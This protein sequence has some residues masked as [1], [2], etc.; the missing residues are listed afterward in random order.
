MQV[1]KRL[2]RLWLPSLLLALTIPACSEPV[3]EG[4]IPFGNPERTRAGAKYAIKES[5]HY[6][7]TEDLHARIELADHPAERAMIAID[8]KDV[9]IDLMG[10]TLGRGQ[11]FI[12][13]GGHGIEIYDERHILKN[14]QARNITIKNGVIENFEIGIARWGGF[15]PKKDSGY[16]RASYDLSLRFWQEKVYDPVYDPV[17]KKTTTI[18]VENEQPIFNE[19]TNTYHFPRNNITLENITFKNNKENF[20]IHARTDVPPPEKP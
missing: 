11:L 4:C 18:P 2:S 6:C 10:H 16:G 12:N 20:R 17:T 8:A 19:K 1:L 15:Y 13:P 7:L 3:P 14:T 5:G 9:T